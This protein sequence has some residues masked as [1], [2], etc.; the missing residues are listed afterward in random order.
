VRG[1]RHPLGRTLRARSRRT[2]TSYRARCAGYS[3]RPPQDR[4]GKGIPTR[5]ERSGGIVEKGARPAVALFNRSVRD[6]KEV[7]ALLQRAQDE[8]ILV[9]PA[10]AC[11]ELPEGLVVSSSTLQV[12]P[13]RGAF[14]TKG[15]GKGGSRG[16]FLSPQFDGRPV[17]R[18]TRDADPPGT[19]MIERQKIV[20]RSGRLARPAVSWR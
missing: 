14:D 19:R 5:L 8:G 17:V 10:S 9:A 4:S 3:S 15:G 2:G 1:R 11:G 16:T 7:T 12:D 6:P 18:S 20:M 13:E